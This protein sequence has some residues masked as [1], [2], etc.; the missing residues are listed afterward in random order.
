MELNEV[1]FKVIQHLM[2]QGRITWSEL[3]GI[4]ELSAPA[5]ADRVRRLEDRSVIRGYAALVNPEA[6]GLHLT[7]FIAVTLERP[8][9][10]DAFLDRVNALTEVQDCHHV[11][12]EDDYLLKVRCR[13]TKDLERLISEQLKALPGILKTRTTI[14]LSTVKETPVLPLYKNGE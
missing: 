6:I 4:L 11:T 7:A 3:A 2:A 14:A 9:H 12:G 5:T 13:H 10:R 8:E 1:D